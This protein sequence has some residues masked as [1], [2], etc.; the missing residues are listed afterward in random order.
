MI[1]SKASIAVQAPLEFVQ[2]LLDLIVTD[3]LQVVIALQALQHRLLVRLAHIQ[4]HE[5]FMN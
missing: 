1:V 4:T 5:V 3:A 2:T